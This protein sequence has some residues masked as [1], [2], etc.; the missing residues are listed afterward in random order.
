M[1]LTQV[2]NR[3]VTGSFVDLLG[4]RYYKIANVDKM[5]PFFISVVSS[6]DH[7][8][9]ISSTGSLSAGR[10]RPEN[11]LFPYKSVDHI[12]ESAEN[13]GS[14]TIVRVQQDGRWVLWEP[15][16]RFHDGLYQVERN[17]YKNSIGDKIVFEELNHTLKLKFQYS[18]ASSEEFGF[19]RR[20]QISDLSGQEREL[21]ILDGLQNLLPS[22]APLAALQ[23][24]SALVD[25]YKWNEQVEGTSL[26]LYTMYAK[27]SDRAEPAESLLATTVFSIDN[28][29]GQILLSSEQLGAF[30]C[31]EPIANEPLTR[32][33]RGSYLINKTIKLSAGQS[34]HWLIV[35]DIDKNH[36]DV[37]ALEQQLATPAN[38]EQQ[39][40]A[41]IAQNQQELVA[42]MSGGD[43]WQVTAEETTFVHHYANVLFNSMRG[44]VIENNYQ[45][46]KQDVLKT[47]RKTNQQVVA[48]Q[49]TFF[50]DLP[51]SFTHA[52]LVRLAKLTGDAQLVRLSYEYLP[53][54]FGRRHGDPSRPW[55]HYEI[56]LKDE[57]GERLL[58]YQGNWRD[59]FQNWEALALSYPGFISSFMAKFVNASTMDGY[60]PYRI[61]KEGIDWELLE[62][63]DPWSNIGYWGD[64]QIIYLLKFLELAKKYQ[65]EEL[66]ELLT[67][68]LF[69]YANVPYELCGVEKLFA[70]PKDTVSFNHE[71][72]QRIEEKVA[73]LGSDGRL[74]LEGEDSVYMV[75]LCEKVLVPLLSKL[76]NLVLD[77]GIWLNTQRPEWNDANNAIVGNGL[78]MVTL[79]YMRRYVAFLQGLMSELPSSV[80]MSKEVFDWMLAITRILQDATKEIRQGTVNRQTRKAILTLL[81]KS[82]DDYRQRVYRM[83]GFSGKTKVE[84]SALE[85]LL[86]A[87]LVVLDS[88]IEN[89]LREDGLYNAY[90]I[91][92]Y[93]GE[94]LNIE[95]LYPMLEGQVAVLSAGVLTPKQAVE[96]LDKLFSSEMYRDD[97]QSFM[98]YPDRQL[99]AF[100]ER[101]R[102]APA[103]VEAN[104]VISEML[105][106]GDQ[107]IVQRDIQG[108]CHFHA[109]FENVDGL[110]KAIAQVKADYPELGKEQWDELDALYEQVFNHRAFTGRSGTMFGYEGLGCIYWHMVSKLLLAVQENYQHAWEQDANSEETKQL[111]QYYYRVRQGIGFNK[112]PQNYGAFPTDPYSHTPKHAGAQQPG[113]TGQ[114]KEE[115]LTRFVELGIEVKEEAIRIQP[116]LLR[117]QEFLTQATTFSCLALS[118]EKRSYVL[119]ADQLAFTYCQVPFIYQISE[120]AQG[121]I[122][123]MMNDDSVQLFD[124][125]EL[126]RNIS[127][128]IFARTGEVEKVVVN[129]PESMLYRG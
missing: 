114:V 79:Y 31:G 20:A 39:I 22:G 10:I 48:R 7:W 50:A 98:L 61:T 27:L 11:A 57:H 23:T 55:N 41:S 90:N 112:T 28:D 3:T 92:T 13:T 88:S 4:E 64:H 69:S 70:N 49:Q 110:R 73:Q 47:M 106:N 124:Q 15:F 42:L 46:D 53:L 111:A 59:I 127:Q 35:A 58:S 17:L 116:T 67:S 66:S 8:L 43:A 5:A 129:L 76:S 9:F 91:L 119:E 6:S 109:A 128:A 103:Q 56:K 97:Q 80:S 118:G 81:E 24:R 89:N 2:K 115:V 123:V 104:R 12:H 84:K 101:N 54:T 14:K 108:D 87:S 117:K 36:C 113:M 94:S 51:E 34:K 86:E 37:R 26:A 125:L 40:E 122:E 78:S 105:A 74:I 95:N 82:A 38:V 19:V 62:A 52:E 83:N 16:N 60:N 121:H 71:L 120:Q 93:S 32:G 21:D 33:V 1:N 102:I 96:L 99:P 65:R 44:G 85:K 25:A 107:R 68:D 30:R 77:G 100:V 75:N 29:Y 18:W 72:Q 126:D 45:L 63:D